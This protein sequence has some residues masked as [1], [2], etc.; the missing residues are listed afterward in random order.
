MQNIVGVFFFLGHI[1]WQES[2]CIVLLLVYLFVSFAELKHTFMTLWGEIETQRQQHIRDR[3]IFLTRYRSMQNEAC[4]PKHEIDRGRQLCLRMRLLSSLVSRC[5][6]L[7]PVFSSMKPPSM[8]A[9]A[10]ELTAPTCSA[11]IATCTVPST[12]VEA[13]FPIVTSTMPT[14]FTMAQAPTRTECRGD[15]RSA[16]HCPVPRMG[17]LVEPLPLRRTAAMLTPNAMLVVPHSTPSTCQAFVNTMTLPACT[18][19]GT[20]TVLTASSQADLRE[21]I[22]SSKAGPVTCRTDRASNLTSRASC[23][24]V[25]WSVLNRSTSSQSIVQGNAATVHRQ[26]E[27]H[28]GISHATSAGSTSLVG[29]LNEKME[30]IQSVVAAVA[31]A[32][33]EHPTPAATAKSM[34]SQQTT[35]SNGS[36]TTA[37]TVA[38]GTA[39]LS[40]SSTLREV[41]L[42]SSTVTS[43][44]RDPSNPTS[45]VVPATQ[46]IPLTPICCS[47]QNTAM[48]N[49]SISTLATTSSSTGSCQ[50]SVAESV[51][52]TDVAPAPT[53]IGTMPVSGVSK[54]SSVPISIAIAAA[55]DSVTTKS[56]ST[57]TKKKSSRTLPSEGSAPSI[58]MLLKAGILACGAGS[59]S[60]TLPLVSTNHKIY[61]STHNTTAHH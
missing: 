5:R 31:G 2:E 34:A 20:S 12:R 15:A 14:S 41:N 36:G 28:G 49:N 9:A 38:I 37:H 35:C 21:G 44:R 27:S 17:S 40:L 26:I 13:A 24:A 50:I 18:A 43:V 19:A 60:L 48:S 29:F 8:V 10:E 56:A 47:S 25:T 6:E 30:S 3:Q 42:L 16:F 51:S 39:G 4:W 52:N 33:R 23:T 58:A 32:A 46:E 57:S 61:L 11:E 1:Y 54:A 45:S 53:T 22:L 55:P 59:L 7:A